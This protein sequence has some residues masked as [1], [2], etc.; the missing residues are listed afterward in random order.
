MN[1]LAA[2][3]AF[4]LF[5]C[6]ASEPPGRGEILTS[7]IPSDVV[8][9]RAAAQRAAAVAAGAPASG[10]GKQILFGDLHVHSTFSP[11]A[12]V[13][14][15]PI[16]GGEGAMPPALACDFARHCSALDFWSINDHAEGVTP[17][18]WR[19][20]VE[21]IRECNASAGDPENPDVVA[22]LGWEWSQIDWERDKHYGHKNVVF[23][24][25]QEVPARPIAAPR[26]NLARSPIGKPAQ[27]LLGFQDWENRDYY[28]SFSDYFD[29]TAATPICEAG[30]DT[31][32]L[33]TECLELASD[34]QEL[35]EKLDQWELESIVIPHGSAWGLNTPPGTSF[36]KQLTPDQ[37][38]PRRQKLIEVYSGHGN[39]EEYRSW[40][41]VTT[42]ADGSLECPM[43]TE[44]FLPCCWRAGELIAE[45]CEKA[46]ESAEECEARAAVARANHV[47]ASVTG[48]WTVPGAE[49]EEWLD[50]GICRDCF[51]PAMEHRPRVTSQYALAISRPGQGD[52]GEDLRFRFGFIGSSDIHRSRP[53]TGYKEFAR[54]GMTEVNGP[55][56]ESM[57]GRMGDH[58]ERIAQSVRYELGVTELGLQVSRPMER[59]AS[60]FM[61]G[62]LVAVHSEG[63]GRELIWD[64]LKRK[65]VYGTSGD[66][67]LLWFDLLRDGASG[68]EAV[69]MGSEV[70]SSS[71]PRF[72][73]RA[74]GALEQKPG[75]PDHTGAALSVEEL[76]R[77]CLGECYNPADTR[78]SIVRIEV[79]RIRPQQREGES[80]D[81]LIEDPWRSFEC[82]GDPV[83]CTVEFDDPEFAAAKRDTVYYVRAIQEPTPAVNAGGVRCDR[84]E[85]GSC[86]KTNLCAGGFPTDPADDC[87]S[88]NEERAWSSP[89]F[90][91]YS[92]VAERPTRTEYAAKAALPANR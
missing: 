37:H 52:S 75:C 10:P 29:E 53:G 42:N 58:R 69:A 54:R 88:P 62:G 48:H 35:F 12:F 40:R 76:Q 65:E 47:E 51:N 50:C 79:V 57:A 25:D 27:L 26:R 1:L 36:D 44:D 6:S 85:D 86:L 82:S 23:L 80:V 43:P 66:R 28:W 67:I 33:P 91:D 19:E 59:Q 90:V 89:I 22:F 24:D 34:P 68:P 56:A 45:R 92:R 46:G 49:P 7:E 8:E 83:G 70:R 20:T 39:S 77:I 74:V 87:L 11:D 55:T 3:A 14:S 81:P 78:H 41:H 72:R 32:E 60:F 30:V 15:M 13:T 71:K 61:T 5:A 21:S 31:R 4:L 2:S 63:R 16:M 9:G 64:A 38:D 84:S 17:R 73:V 18:R